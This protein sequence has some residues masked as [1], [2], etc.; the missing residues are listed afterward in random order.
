MNLQ[1]SFNVSNHIVDGSIRCLIVDDDPKVMQA[2][3]PHLKQAFDHIEVAYVSTTFA[4]IKNA[5]EFRPS[6]VIIEARL[7]NSLGI[8]LIPIFKNNLP[9]VICIVLTNSREASIASHAIHYGADDYVLKPLD[10][11]YLIDVI[12]EKMSRKFE[13]SAHTEN[14]NMLHTMFKHCANMLMMMDKTGAIFDVNDALLTTTG[15]SKEELVGRNLVS[16]DMWTSDSR[17][18]K[19]IRSRLLKATSGIFIRDEIGISCVNNKIT[20]VDFSLKPI[21]DDNGNVEYILFEAREINM[22]KRNE[23]KL[24]QLAHYD[25]L[26]QLPNRI[27]FND[28]LA[29]SI[30]GAKRFNRVIAVLFIDIDNFKMINDNFGHDAGDNIL[31]VTASKI[32]QCLREIDTVSRLGGDEFAVILSE[33]KNNDTTIETAKRIIEAVSSPIVH[34]EIEMNI[35]ASIGIALYPDDATNISELL[36]HADAAMYEA[37]QKGKNNYF[38]YREMK[39]ES[40]DISM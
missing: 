28:R 5:Y 19:K 23:R 11:D 21:L 1:T 38:F 12:S 24:Y 2:L 36:S 14:E 25:H 7:S 20:I 26:T 16:V 17:T 40:S 34:D 8:N 30:R 29:Q 6:L 35:T 9:G 10:T 27:L 39:H 37:K 15:F 22:Y 33:V 13:S 3:N 4:A 18:Q 31:Q 32:R